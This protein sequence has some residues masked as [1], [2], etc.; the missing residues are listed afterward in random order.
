MMVILLNVN[1]ILQY[2]VHQ[3][4]SLHNIHV[5][6]IVNLGLYYSYDRMA[7]FCNIRYETI[8]FTYM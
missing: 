8:V 2:N 3:Q 6:A 7:N 1:L 5:H 4:Q